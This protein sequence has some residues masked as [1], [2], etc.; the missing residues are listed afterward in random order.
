MDAALLAI[1]DEL[2]SGQVLDTNGQWLVE[3]LAEQGVATVHRALVPDRAEAVCA[4]LMDWAQRVDWILVTGGL[5][6][7]AD[8]Q[9]LDGVARALGVA[10]TLHGPS[11]AALEARARARG[12]VLA[13]NQR[14]MALLP[15]G[16]EALPN[17]VG[18]APGVLARLGRAHCLVLPG[19]PREMKAMFEAERHRLGQGPAPARRSLRFMEVSES[20]LDR[21][22]GG[23]DLP[24]G[25]QVGFRNFHLENEVKLWACGEGA[26]ERM[27]LAEAAL[28]DT[29]GPAY[30]LPLEEAVGATLKAGGAT[31]ATA[32]SCTGGYLGQV[33]TRTPGSSAYV[34]GGVI[35]Y[36]NEVKQDMLGVDPAVLA[37]HG[38]VS[39]AVA[40]AMAEGVRRRLHATW[41]VST[42][43]VAGPGGG[44]ADKPV[45]TVWIAW[46]GPAGTE[47]RRLELS[48]DRE[49]VRFRTVQCALY[50]LLHRL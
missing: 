13:E 6:P 30:G 37:E 7:T 31:V 3:R 15:A 11:L 40:R 48:G 34:L 42:T 27:A 12:R 9:T 10:R 1:G 17:P 49:A 22:I 26:E 35:A 23:L 41:G 5:G 36:A 19:V 29:P 28:V 47:A 43:G 24:E 39:E 14:R 45:G 2:L 38:A 16:V 50:G 32:E 20:E 8:D 25:V 4:A 33:L 21:W 18:A 46:A 44:S